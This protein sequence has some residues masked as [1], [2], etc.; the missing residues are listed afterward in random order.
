MS[1]KRARRGCSG[2]TLFEKWRVCLLVGV[3]VCGLWLLGP[4]GRVAGGRGRWLWVRSVGLRAAGL[5]WPVSFRAGWD[6]VG[7]CVAR[8]ALWDYGCP[9]TS[10]STPVVV[11]RT[12]SPA[13]VERWNQESAC[14]RAMSPAMGA[15]GETRPEAERHDDEGKAATG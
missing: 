7:V 13:P 3:G 4:V 15:R 8:R 5:R 9:R 1:P 12:P 10:P 6:A 2:T 11:R 14:V